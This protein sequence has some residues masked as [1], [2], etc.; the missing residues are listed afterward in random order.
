MLE[1][2]AFLWG[3]GGGYRGTRK[4]DKTAEYAGIVTDFRLF[5]SLLAHR[6]GT[7]CDSSFSDETE[8]GLK[9]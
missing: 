8:F 4:V 2:R 3:H 7:K 6:S 1:L 9:R 5:N